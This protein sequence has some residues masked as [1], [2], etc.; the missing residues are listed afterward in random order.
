MWLLPS[1]SLKGSRHIFL[2]G[3]RRTAV[4]RLCRSSPYPGGQ[5]YGLFLRIL[6]M[7]RR[8]EQPAKIV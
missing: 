3:Q 5:I 4:D 1:W 8:E 6:Q 7:N 2:M